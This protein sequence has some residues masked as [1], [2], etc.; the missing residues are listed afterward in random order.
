MGERETW[1]ASVSELYD[2][3]VMREIYYNEDFSVCNLSNTCYV[4]FEYVVSNE[5]NVPIGFAVSARKLEKYIRKPKLFY[6]WVGSIPE[7]QLDQNIIYFSDRI[8]EKLIEKKQKAEL[9]GP[10][11]SLEY[12]Q[13]LIETYS[14]AG[15]V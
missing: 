15:R 3:G 12:E 13:Y 14:Q 2:I 9:E 5:Q 8:K 10:Q 7:D 4:I 11:I 6:K 1:L